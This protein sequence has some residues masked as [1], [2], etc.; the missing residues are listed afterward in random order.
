MEPGV[1]VDHST[2]HL[3]LEKFTHHGAHVSRP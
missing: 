3:G 2:V 1:F